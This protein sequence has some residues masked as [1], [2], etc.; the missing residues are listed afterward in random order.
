MCSQLK[1]SGKQPHKK[2]NRQY[3]KSFQMEGLCVASREM[4]L[5]FQGP[6][7]F[8]SNLIIPFFF[9]ISCEWI[10]VFCFVFVLFFPETIGQ[11]P[12]SFSLSWWHD[13]CWSY[14]DKSISDLGQFPFT[15]WAQ[16]AGLLVCPY[17]RLMK[18]TLLDQAWEV[19]HGDYVDD[20]D[21][22]YC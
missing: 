14:L 7:F 2:L 18:K 22:I 11:L 21:Q 15:L 13:F 10:K 17:N 5:I 20:Y 19:G 16:K 12:L 6:L 9:L 4:Q 1:C 8:P 3:L